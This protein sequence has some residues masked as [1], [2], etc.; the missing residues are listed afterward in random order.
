MF[1][2]SCANAYSYTYGDPLDANDLSGE[3]TLTLRSNCRPREGA[4]VVFAYAGIG[5]TTV[6]AQ[7]SVKLAHTYHPPADRWGSPVGE[8][9]N[10]GEFTIAVG[11]AEAFEEPGPGASVDRVRLSVSSAFYDIFAA[12]VVCVPLPKPPS[13]VV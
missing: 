3:E 6:S 7:F 1:Q 10:V 5:P 8:R 4:L 9:I 11:F 2:G 13:V 12:E